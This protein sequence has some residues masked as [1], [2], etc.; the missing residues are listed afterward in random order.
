MTK[1][2]FVL[3]TGQWQE[4]TERSATCRACRIPLKDQHEAS[5]RDE[6][7][8]EPGRLRFWGRPRTSREAS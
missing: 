1:Q 7:R 5:L 3:G 8:C 6:V 2:T 4:A